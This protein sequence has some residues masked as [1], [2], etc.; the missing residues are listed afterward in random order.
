MKNS[1]QLLADFYLDILKQPKVWQLRN[2][3]LIYDLEQTLAFELECSVETVRRI[4]ERMA[5]EDERH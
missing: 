2:T 4:F 5:T 1:K 3:L